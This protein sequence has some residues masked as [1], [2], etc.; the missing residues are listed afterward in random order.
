MSGNDFVFEI[1]G[2]GAVVCLGNNLFADGP[3][4]HGAGIGIEAD[5]RTYSFDDR[6]QHIIRNQFFWGALEETERM[7][8]AAVEGLLS[9]GVGELQ[10]EKTAVA[11]QDGQAVELAR[12]IPIGNRSEVA[13]IHLVGSLWKEESLSISQCARQIGVPPSGVAQVLRG[14]KQVHPVKNAI[15]NRLV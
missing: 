9:L 15:L 5:E 8:E 2:E 6:R 7:E 3:R 11:F 12:C 1:D 14:K 13:P 4:G 10:V